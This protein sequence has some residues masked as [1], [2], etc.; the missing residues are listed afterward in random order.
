MKLH[1]PI[2]ALLLLAA[3]SGCASLRTT[4]PYQP[5]VS[6]A[7]RLPMMPAA[8]GELTDSIKGPL[9]LAR[10][11]E[12]AL[13]NNPDIRVGRWDIES[14]R[15]ERDVVLAQGLPNIRG[16]GSYERY[17]DDQRLVSPSKVG[18]PNIA[19]TDEILAANVVISMPLFTGGRIINGIRA[20]ELLRRAAEHRLVRTKSDLVF[21]VSSTFYAILGQRRVIESLEFSQRALEEHRK[22]VADLMAVQKAAKVDLL[23][24]EV[25]LASIAQTLLLEKGVLEIQKRLLANLLGIAQEENLLSIEG[26]LLVAEV[27]VDLHKSL[28]EAYIQRDDYLAAKA[29]VEALARRVDAARAERWP[30]VSLEGSYGGRWVAG[31]YTRPTGAT[32]SEDVG[33]A[34]VTVNV[35]VFEGGRINAEIHRERARL[36]AAQETL[37]KL[38]LQIRLEVQTAV[39]NVTSNRERVRAT[40]KAIEQGRESLR[41]EREKYDLGKGSITDVLDAQAALLEA[42]TDYYRALVDYNTSVAQLRVAVG[43]NA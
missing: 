42:E 20:A 24:T 28:E 31:A 36:A 21:N 1:Q 3:I 27:P 29:T 17:Q 15:A 43:E 8:G 14:A 19:L 7:S 25:R 35:P 11:I 39:V 22:R 34:R 6:D 26:E 41:I 18:V 16:V 33:S 5:I 30:V 13:T 40:E 38:E 9:T 37:R 12:I 2:V 32:L 4:D 10:C 23:R